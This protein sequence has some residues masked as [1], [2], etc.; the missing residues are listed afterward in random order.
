ML[1]SNVMPAAFSRLLFIVLVALAGWFGISRLDFDVDPL[2]LLPQDL[3]GLEGTRLLRD[4]KSDQL[5]VT[6]Q[7]EDA[8]L[9]EVVADSLAEHLADKKD[10][11]ASVKHKSLLQSDPEVIAEVI[12]WLWRNA[13]PEKVAEL[14]ASLAADKLPALLDKS[15]EATANSLDLQ[16]ATL[17]GYDPFGI[18]RGALAMLSPN[19]DPAAMASDEFTSADGTLRLLFIEPPAEALADYRTV[20]AWL[21]K[22]RQDIRESWQKSDEAL[23]KVQIG[24]TGDPAFQA[25]IATGME[26]DM[27]QSISAVTFIVGFLFW[28]L[29]RRIVPL[30]WLL[31][32]IVC[33]NLL[34]LGAAGAIYGSLNVMSMG[35]AAILTGLIED[36][37]VIGLHAAS[38]HP[39]ESY[40]QIR[41]RVLPGVAWSAVTIAAIFA[42]LGL[43][44]LPGVAQL[45]VLAALGVLIGAAVM[46]LGFLPLGMKPYVVHASACETPAPRL[47]LTLQK[48]FTWLLAGLLIAST[49]AI[50]LKGLPKADFGSSVLRPKQ[51]EAFDISEQI[52]AK[53]ISSDQTVPLLIHAANADQL[54]HALTEA[55]KLLTGLP[56]TLPTALIPDS[57]N[58]HSNTPT[59]QQLA[60]SE[61][62]LQTALATAG[63]TDT[64]FS[65][66]QKVL[67]KWRSD[68]STL[69][70]EHL[71][72][73][74]ASP[75]GSVTALG[76]FSP[77]Q[78]IHDPLLA[79]LEAI[80]GVHPAGWNYLRVS[81]EPLLEREITR[82]CLPTAGLAIVLFALVFHGWRE[83][84]HA[85]GVLLASAWVLLGSMTAFDWTWNLMSIGAVPLCLG[86]GLDFTIHMMHTLREKG[87]TAAHAASLGRSLAYCGLS[88]GLAFGALATGSNRGLISLGLITMTGVLTVLLASSFA[89]PRV[90]FRRCNPTPSIP[91]SNTIRREE[92]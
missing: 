84:L 80:P 71:A 8:E 74:S 81:L 73:I 56:H 36:F 58:Q 14:N 53:M 20:N 1:I 21:T 92:E 69:S 75:D 44:Q 87:A 76:S 3:P 50:S 45:G 30:F 13:P 9:L 35:F 49:I 64:A 22:L 59:L 52:E 39:R 85:A 18:A 72:L 31:L 7:S 17:T 2:S 51:S 4:L 88:T 25:E 11:A 86:L 55:S 65:L 90:W 57:K 79:K 34:T 91:A 60:A 28:L 38:E 32:A 89:L 78:G 19:G 46:L 66:T 23:A 16:N 63:F 61:K 77:P 27:R 5:I 26:A 15:R 41:R 54:R 10:L 42:A 43:S 6:L 37:G 40:A 48:A 33:A 62:A 12:A 67:A 68:T 82:V 70:T 29:H 47:G 83:R 24:F